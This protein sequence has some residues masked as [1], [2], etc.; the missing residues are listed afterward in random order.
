MNLFFQI[1]MAQAEAAAKPQPSTF[2]QIL[3]FIVIF[4]IFYFFL[5]RP[6]TKK[7]KEHQNLIGSLKAG[8]EVITTGGIIG[9]V[10]SV[11][12]LF[13]TLDV[14]NGTLIKVLKSNVS[15]NA[16]VLTKAAVPAKKA[17]SKA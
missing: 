13:I 15:Q 7:V 4:G 12:D 3:P 14:G 9:K 5:I 11:A 17:E 8:D 16:Q 2:E 1:A 10:K 6:Q